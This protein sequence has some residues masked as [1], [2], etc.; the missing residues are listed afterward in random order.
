MPPND[1]YI[2]RIALDRQ[3]EL[4][5]VADRNRSLRSARADSAS[6]ARRRL[7]T[8]LIRWAQR[9]D[10]EGARPTGSPRLTT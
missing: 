8:W 4:I 1:V 6:H 10:P 5:G 3:R 7:A 9:L 2:A